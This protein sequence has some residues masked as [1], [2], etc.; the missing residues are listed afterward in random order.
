MTSRVS[1]VGA[2]RSGAVTA[3]CLADLGHSVCA[4]DVNEALRLDPRIGAS[5]YL[6]P[7]IGFGGSC[8]PK[9]LR[10]LALR[11][12]MRSGVLID[13]RNLLDGTAAVAAGFSY[14]AIGRPYMRD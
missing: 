1:V 12:V 6:A 13:A 7:G 11:G 10:A 4:V 9:D 3:A 14:F 5:A 8:L 2:G